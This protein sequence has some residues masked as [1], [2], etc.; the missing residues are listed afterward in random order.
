M[1]IPY[2][3]SLFNSFG[4]LV[5]NLPAGIEKRI[6][7]CYNYLINFVK[8]GYA[9]FT[10]IIIHMTEIFTNSGLQNIYVPLPFAAHLLFCIFAT[11]VYALETYR[12][13]SVHYI[14]IAAGVDATLLMQFF[15]NSTMVIILAVMEVIFLG[16]AITLSVMR[17]RKEKAEKKA[18]K[19][20]G[21]GK[22]ETQDPADPRMTRKREDEKENEDSDT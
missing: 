6:K 17:S 14:F 20:A 9:F 8:G 4:K 2:F 3:Y 7:P 12:K 13:K 5:E 22:N 15:P 18:Q 16:T 11:A 19:E 1:S 21:E 10:G